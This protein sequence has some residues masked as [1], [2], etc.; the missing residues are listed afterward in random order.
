[1]DFLFTAKYH[2]YGNDNSQNIL[3]KVNKETS[4][5]MPSCKHELLC[6]MNDIVNFEPC[7]YWNKKVFNQT[8]S[9]LQNIATQCPTLS[10]DETIFEFFLS[11]YNAY[12]QVTNVIN[13]LSGLNDSPAMKNRQFRIPTYVS[14]V[15]GCL[16]NL[17]RFIALIVNQTTTKDYASTYK[18]KSLCEILNGNGFDELTEFVNINIRNAINHGGIIFEEDGQKIIFH[19]TENKRSVSSTFTTYEFDQLINDVYDT[20]SA[21]IL[22][23]AV[24]LNLNWK[25]VS[26]DR[27]SKTFVA[28]SMLGMEL[29][30]PTVRCR[31]ISE[32][33]CSD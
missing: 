22:G 2:Y 6:V 9:A 30:T 23:I 8:D 3:Q 25:A 13:D 14:V 4:K 28:F 21:I 29:S 26:V 11:G 20:A 15:E 12:M 19:Y 16:T 32:S 17:Y 18:L 24:F 27:S 10:I 1:M 5:D 7:C 33:V 31:Y